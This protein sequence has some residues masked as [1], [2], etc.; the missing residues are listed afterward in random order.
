MEAFSIV[1][2]KENHESNQYHIPGGT[3]EISATIKD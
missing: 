2:V 1:S 3:V